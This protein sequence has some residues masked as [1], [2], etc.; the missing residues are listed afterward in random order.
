MVMASVG[1]IAAG[2]VVSWLKLENSASMF[3][4]A[5]GAALVMGLYSLTLPHT[6]PKGANAPISLGTLL[7][8]DAL[9]LMRDR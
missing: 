9:K 3:H 4:L 5:A 6:P 8:L 2:L 7:G 1:W